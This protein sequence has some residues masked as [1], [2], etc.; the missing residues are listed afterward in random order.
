M[1]RLDDGATRLTNGK[2]VWQAARPTRMRPPRMGEVLQTDVVIVGAGITGGFLAERFTRDGHGVVLLDRRAPTQ[3]STSA[4]TAMLLWELDA[5]L[6]ELERRMG[7]ARAGRVARTCRRVVGE[8]GAVVKQLQIPCDYAPRH[9]LYMA[10]DTLDAGDLCEEKRLRAHLGIDGALLGEAELAARGIVADAALDYDGSAEADPVR[11]AQGLLA[12]AVARGALILSPA[13]ATDYQA[14]RQGVSVETDA[15]SAVHARVLALAT[16]YEM[17]DFVP[18]ARH[19]LS[20]SWSMATPPLT[21]P[22]WRD[23]ALVWEASD[24]YLYMRLTGDG[25]L[26]IGGEDEDSDD[27]AMRE[28][29]TREKIGRLI[30]KAKLHCPRLA[31]VE[32]EF[33]WSGVF[34][35]TDDSLP[36]IGRVPGRDNCLAAF[37]YGG[38]GITFSALAAEMLSAEL[39][40]ARHPDA[41]LFALDRDT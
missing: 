40:G 4:S 8:I 2:S 34:G 21:T 16:G 29:L 39:A 31:R 5:S 32:A 3:G 28:R 24:P 38:N 37:G 19:S 11:L 1:T 6:L 26:I 9:S 12:A 30:A 14:T 36:L 15:G 25:R 13:T 7:V 23:E 20:S 10:G 35:K 22:P 41:D 17:P 33:A 18:A 27:A